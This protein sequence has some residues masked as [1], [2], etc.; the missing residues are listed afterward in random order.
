M[1][2]LWVKT[3]KLIPVDTGGKIRT[4]NI[5]CRL[6]KQFET[7]LLSYYDGPL[8]PAYEAA[9]L[10]QF[11]R[12]QLISTGVVDAGGFRSVLRYA[13]QLPRRAPY[14][15]SKFTHR[16][17]RK[18][19]A[20]AVASGHFDLLICDFLAA[21]LNFPD[22]PF[23]PCILFQ[24]NVESV[25]WKR[26]TA[27]ESHFPRKLAYAYEAARMLSYE[28]QALSKFHHIL[29]VSEQDREQMLKMQPH[30]EI[31][32]IP[33]GVDV[34]ES[35]LAPPSSTR[36]PRIVFS[37]SM[38]WEPNVDAVVYFCA[39][40][41]PQ[42]LSEF[43]DAIFQI[44]GRNPLP[45]VKRLASKSV[46]VTGTVPS[47]N[48]YIKNATV[49]VVPLRIGGGTRLKIYEAMAFGKA[50]VSTSIGAE[51]LA[52]QNGRD[53]LLADDTSS[54]ANAILMLLRDDEIRGK[55]EHA[56]RQLA[57]QHD[58]SEVV[59][60]FSEVLRNIV[61]VSSMRETRRQIAFQR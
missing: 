10:R 1:R 50:L 17:V 28:R 51:G 9:L 43:P 41:W 23:I 61:A 37:G 56:A 30:C 22:N 4:Y 27:A 5:L 2:V 54:F 12:S 48:E 33:T 45:R 32:V 13:R 6:A 39:Q 57:V 40:I 42:L 55:F 19:V 18:A 16:I 14:S 38:D 11:P 35:L 47:V 59:R 29:C 58:W 15:V 53:L 20:D 36:P 8:D 21:S 3:G 7:R 34:H 44:V 60:K 26:M 49:V 24:H 52:F 31:T 25:L 46:L